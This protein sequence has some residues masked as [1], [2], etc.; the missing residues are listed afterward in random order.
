[1]TLE[2][3]IFQKCKNPGLVYCHVKAECQRTFEVFN[4]N[5]FI[6]KPSNEHDW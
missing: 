3:G 2:R 1:M 6:S 5:L 4:F